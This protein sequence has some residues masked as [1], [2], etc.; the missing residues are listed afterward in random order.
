[1]CKESTT[2]ER[3]IFGPPGTGKTTFLEQQLGIE[4]ERHGEHSILVASF[5]RAAAAEIR[6][7]DLAIPE[8]HVGTLH[9][10][11]YRSMGCPPIA[12]TRKGFRAWNAW[13]EAQVKTSIHPDT[14]LQFQ[15]DGGKDR[16]PDDPYEDRFEAEEGEETNGGDLLSAVN[17]CRARMYLPESLEWELCCGRFKCSGIV[18]RGF[19]E[20]WTEFKREAGM[21]DFAD[22]IAHGQICD[23]PDGASILFFD[24]CQDFASSELAVVRNWS[25]KANLVFL[26]G[27]DD[28][29]IYGFRGAT[30]DAFLDP[31]IPDTQKRVLSRSYRLPAAVKKVS[32]EWIRQLSRREPKE[33]QPRGHIDGLDDEG[34]VSVLPANWSDGSETI[35]DVVEEELD[36]G[37]TVMVLALCSYMLNGPR[38]I[39]KELRARGV[40]FH[41]PYRVKRGDWNPM[42][43]GARRLLA[44]LRP[45]LGSPSRLWSWGELNAWVDLIDAK[46]T[47]LRRGA[48]RAI[49]T[50][51]CDQEK[52][53]R[54]VGRDDLAVL[55]Q[56][57]DKVAPWTMGDTGLLL[58]NAKNEKDE[59]ALGYPAQ[60]LKTRGVEALSKEPRCVVEKIGRAHV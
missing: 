2:N 47:E 9:S 38:G 36:R 43:G 6:G 1:M 20:L 49:S 12:E 11:C 17:F 3:R 33:F 14:I 44:Y 39:V 52:K 19:H 22:M 16:D 35:V 41:N 55:F 8:G 34:E 58:A 32:D 21:I 5:T 23:P 31:P 56:G 25:R 29:A 42:R 24:E 15:L 40:P 48:K 10:L 27:D 45:Q 50:M 37:R 54:V 4:A 7:R 28:Q 46:K 59:K 57:W 53:D 51:A 18:A 60:V 30:P 26:A 13:L